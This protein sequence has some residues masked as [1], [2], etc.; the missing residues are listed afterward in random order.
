MNSSMDKIDES[1]ALFVH[2]LRDDNRGLL[3]AAPPRPVVDQVP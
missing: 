3:P 2:G 1:V